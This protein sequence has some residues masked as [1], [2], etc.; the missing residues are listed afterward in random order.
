MAGEAGVGQIPESDFDSLMQA[1]SATPKGRS[2]LAEYRKRV[3]AEETFALLG[4]L[5]RIEAAIASVRDQ[6]QPERI[7]DELHRVAMTLEIAIEGVEADAAGDETARRTA[8]ISRARAELSGLAASLSGRSA[9]P[10]EAEAD[11][12][13]RT[14]DEFALADQPAMETREASALR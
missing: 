3:R 10:R 2:F 12:L 1:L 9:L 7:A 8:L 4:E 13:A 5:R 11:A 6:L 14:S